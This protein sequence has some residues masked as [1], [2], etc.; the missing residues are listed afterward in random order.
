VPTVTTTAVSSITATTAVSGGNVT[1]NGGG[2]VTA[3]GVVYSTTSTPTLTSGTV[4]STSPVTTSGSYSLSMS[5]LTAGI[6]YYVRAYATN[7]AGTAYGSQISFA[8][9][10]STDTQAPTAPTSLASSSVTSSSVTLA[11]TASTDN[12]AVTGYNVYQNSILVGT[13]T[14]TTYAVTGLAASTAYT[15]YI[16]AKDA[17]G[18]I[19]SA[20]SSLAVT[21]SSASVTYCTSKGTNYSY[22]WIDLVQLNT[23]NN[24]TAANAGYG[25]FTSLSTTLTKGSSYTVYFSAGFKSSA[26]TEYWYIWIDYNNNGSFE[27]TEL[28][29]S[30]SSSLATTLSKTFT[31]PATATA[32]TTRMRVTMKYNSA[33]TA[34]ET[35]SYGEVE[36]YTIV[37]ADGVADTQAPTAPA[38][39]A[40]SGVTATTATLSWTASTDNVGVTGYNVYKNGTLLGTSTGT[41]YSVTGLTASTAYSFYVTAYDAAGNLS[42]A[43]ST[44]S[45]TTSAASV[46]YCASKGSNVTYEWIDLVQ[47]NT[48]N[49]VTTANAG[50]GDFTSLST[51]LSLG[52]SYTIY[53]SAG[54]KSTAYTEYWYIWI[55]YDHDGS[56]ESTELISSGSSKLATTLSKTFTVP[57]TATIGSTRMRVT[58]KYNSAP[59]ACETFSYGEV[60]DYTVVI[61]GTSSTDKGVCIDSQEI[62]NELP[63]SIS[64]FPNPTNSS[65]TVKADNGIEFTN[66]TARIYN[67]NGVL[68]KIA[69]V[70]KPIDVSKLPAGIYV[71]KVD[72]P[73]ESL[74]TRFIKQ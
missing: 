63:T 64:V 10:T 46:T 55:D 66:N 18:N 37:L 28:I 4:L 56:F 70:D 19:S 68:V 14:S 50:Y 30:T 39:L 41:T 34:C 8:T 57:S 33:P 53:F 11:W 29:N 6:T 32:G 9:S 47:L 58:M 45:V 17:A 71:I 38:N 22:E 65:I 15:F 52:T 42:S 35:F 36:D 20:S 44:L 31:V 60:E 67:S 54:F 25:D 12:V 26:Y 13:T 40:S 51:N 2:T 21:T 62:G 5:G 23:I 24:V 74:V 3:S 49:N 69:T 59:T 61:T 1:A 73:K 27:S 72:D 48:I 7:S 16:T 43:S